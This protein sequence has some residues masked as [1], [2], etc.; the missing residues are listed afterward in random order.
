M[1]RN[2]GLVPAAYKTREGFQLGNWVSTQRINKEDLLLDRVNRLES[3]KEWS[4]D[5]LTAAWEKAYSCLKTYCKEEGNCLVPATYKT[6]DGFELGSWVSNQRVRADSVTPDRRDRLESLKGWSWD[7]FTTAWEEAYSH[8]KAYCKTEG[9]CSVPQS[10]TTLGGFRLGWWVTKQREKRDTMTDERRHRLERLEGWTWDPRT[11]L[12]EEGYG[13]LEAFCKSEGNCSVPDN[14][15]TKDGFELGSWVRTQR[16]K[17]DTITDERR[18][19]RERLKG[20]SWDPYADAWEKAYAY[21]KNY[22][23]SEGDCLVPRGHKTKERFNLGS[24]VNTQRARKDTM[25]VERRRR[26]E[27]LKGWSWDPM[28]AV[29]EQGYSHLKTYCKE[30]G[31]CLVPRSHETNDGFKVGHWVNNLRADKEDLSSERR[32][33]LEG[34]KGWTWDP[35]DYAWE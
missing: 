33:R 6:K 35:H 30:K 9:H 34:L 16:V 12:W 19:R 20:W 3:L 11:N 31:D 21:L 8:L 22:C 28:A 10:Y 32:R 1:K 23:K 15:K 4:W 27:N 26:L 7:P 17:K 14:Y 18:H 29:W 25:T 13:Y 2:N 24:W 5:P